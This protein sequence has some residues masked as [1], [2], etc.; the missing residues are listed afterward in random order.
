MGTMANDTF[1]MRKAGFPRS[2]SPTT[3]SL[4]V[5][6]AYSPPRLGADPALDRYG[7][8]ADTP[9]R[10]AR[11]LARVVSNAYLTAKPIAAGKTK[12]DTTFYVTFDPENTGYAGDVIGDKLF[13]FSIG[14]GNGIGTRDDGHHDVAD[15]AGR[16]FIARLMLGR[17]R[18]SQQDGKFDPDSIYAQTA[19]RSGSTSSRPSIKP[20]QGPTSAGGEHQRHDLRHET[21]RLG[22]LVLRPQPHGVESSLIADTIGMTYYFYESYA[23][24]ATSRSALDPPRLRR[25]EVRHRRRPRGQP[26]RTAPTS[27]A[28]RTT[29]LYVAGMGGVISELTLSRSSST[30]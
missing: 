6:S 8:G 24:T 1:G 3:R 30:A 21:L 5:T 11:G 12:R 23:D 14:A 20:E 27:T 13:E 15:P 2:S 25:R 17:G 7:Y 26:R 16:K 4:R 19:S 10:P 29:T 28:P 18:Y 22:L 9:H